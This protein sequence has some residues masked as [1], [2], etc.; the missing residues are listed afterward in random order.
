MMA[1]IDGENLVWRYQSMVKAGRKPADFVEHRPDVFV[2]SS[3]TVENAGHFVLRTIYYTSVQGADEVIQDVHTQMKA[4][5][6]KSVGI[7]AAPKTVYPK[8]FRK[9]SKQAKSKGVDIQ[10][11]VDILTNC[12]LNTI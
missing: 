9:F 8:L 6:L 10:M 1:F 12:Y 3:G 2:W 7:A 5:T 11:T 4:L